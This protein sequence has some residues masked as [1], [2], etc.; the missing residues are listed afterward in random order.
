MLEDLLLDSRKNTTDERFPSKK[1]IIS[2]MSETIR[3]WVLPKAPEE[4]PRRGK[5]QQLPPAW[6]HFVT[7][8]C[9]P[10]T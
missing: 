10:W 5:R 6:S 7:A 9:E 8:G 3:I 2:C 4:I 1:E